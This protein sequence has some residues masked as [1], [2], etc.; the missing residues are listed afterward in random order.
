M[1]LDRL[2]DR[3]V[4]SD[5][6]L[7]FYSRVF[8]PQA[9]PGAL[10]ECLRDELRQTGYYLCAGY[11]DFNKCARLR[12]PGRFD[13]V[14]T[15]CPPDGEPIRVDGLSVAKAIRRAWKRRDRAALGGLKRPEL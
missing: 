15:C 9:Q 8:E 5:K 10:A 2:A 13:I 6:C 1:P 14:L 3:L 11:P 12:V 7:Q 4:F